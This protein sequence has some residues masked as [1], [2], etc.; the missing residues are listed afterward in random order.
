VDITRLIFDDGPI[1]VSF[2]RDM[3]ERKQTRDLIIQSEKMAMVGGLAAGMAHEINN[4]IGIIIQNLQNI[5]RRI[6]VDSPDNA[7]VAEEVGISLPLVR[8]YLERRSIFTLMTKMYSAGER[9]A[10]IVSN[11][12]Q[13]SHRSDSEH[14]MVSLPDIIERAVELAS[15]DYDLK[16]KYNF[17]NIRIIRNFAAD[18]PQVSANSMELEQ[19]IINVLKN[20]AHAMMEHGAPGPEI[21]IAVHCEDRMA[22]I[23]LADNGPG[24]DEAT[25]SRIFEPF[26]TTKEVG[27]GTGLGLSVSYTLITQN[28]K[29]MFSVDSAPGEGA[30]FTIKLPL[31]QL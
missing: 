25:R 13:F 23:K 27:V 22:V 8:T 28:H 7:E 18:L 11:M 14:T 12:L 3:T 1:T 21:N 24:M 2:A 10:K 29:G 4:P 16:K 9:A 5:E 30:C 20:A 15:N 17:H 6:S 31:N 26:F 19:V